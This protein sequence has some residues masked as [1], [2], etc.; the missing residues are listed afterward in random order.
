MATYT[1]NL[2][3]YNP[4][5]GEIG[6][7]SEWDTNFSILDTSIGTYLNADGSFKDAT[8][9]AIPFSSVGFTATNVKDA[10]IEAAADSLITTWGSITGTLSAQLDLQS[11]LDAKLSLSG[12]IMTGELVFQEVDALPISGTQAG[13]VYLTTDN[14]LYVWQD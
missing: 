4:A 5:L 1:T 9:K 3:L 7:K 6:W 14:H 8:A 13:V 10:I 11:A 12:G 2:N